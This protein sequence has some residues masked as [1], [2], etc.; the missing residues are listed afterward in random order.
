MRE[1]PQEAGLVLESKIPT[2]PAARRKRLG[3]LPLLF[4]CLATFFSPFPTRGWAQSGGSG[5]SNASGQ[6]GSQDSAN[7]PQQQAPP[8]EAGGPQDDSGPY[9]IPKVD[10]GRQTAAPPPRPAPKSTEGTPSYSINVD[11]P[12]VSLD[13]LVL[14]KDGHFIPGLQKEQFRVLEDDVE[15]PIQSFGLT[16]AGYTAVLL[17][18]FASTPAFQTSRQQFLY[19]ALHASYAFTDQ[20]QEKD[21]VS[22]ISY[23]LKPS[24]LVDFT[25]DKQAIYSAL[26]TL[27]IPGFSETNLFDALYDTLD[28]VDRIAGRKEIILISS[29]IDTFSKINLDKLLKKIKDTP[30]VTIYTISTGF[31]WR[32]HMAMRQGMGAAIQNTDFLQA[33]NQMSTFAKMTGGRWFSPRFQTE[34]P[35]DFREIASTVR[36][37][38][39]LTY[40][41]TNAKLD[42]SYR[43]L[44]VELVQPGTDKPLVVKNESGKELK[45]QVITREGYTARHPVE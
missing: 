23:D 15:Q 43:K 1:T 42:G 32:E 11:V 12:L 7:H 2:T 8:P 22:V 31:L 45:Y 14:T 27:R 39:T 20:M 25:S 16:K 17:V 38:Y 21:F 18:E 33:D 44:K 35:D 36:N 34:L 41:P 26:N 24:I 30:N 4:F 3:W 19:D 29:G 37:Q 13:A 9:A 5:A 28:R 10:S 40:R 6:T